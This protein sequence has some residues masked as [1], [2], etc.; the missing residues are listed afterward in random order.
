MTGVSS[1]SASAVAEGAL[2]ANKAL[3]LTSM[4]AVGDAGAHGSWS[5]IDGWSFIPGFATVQAGDAWRDCA[6]GK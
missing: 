1:A 2:E 3:V 5:G 4:V 6:Y